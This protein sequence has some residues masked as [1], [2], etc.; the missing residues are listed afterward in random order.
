[1]QKGVLSYREFL[2]ESKIPT[3]KKYRDRETIYNYEKA[4]K[5]NYILKQIYDKGFL[6]IE[7]LNNIAEKPHA[8][9]FS[10]NKDF[11]RSEFIR[12]RRVYKLTRWGEKLVEKV[13]GL[14]EGFSI[15]DSIFNE[16]LVEP[17]YYK[18]DS[19]VSYNFWNPKLLADDDNELNRPYKKHKDLA[20]EIEDY[21]NQSKSK[22]R[23]KM[24][25]YKNQVVN[26]SGKVQIKNKTRIQKIKNSVRWI[27][28]NVM[29]YNKVPK[30]HEYETALNFLMANSQKK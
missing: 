10:K 26:K 15:N 12:G 18:G 17:S 14:N 27:I 9:W 20:K 6:T 3:V 22:F 28:K 16:K 11:V 5:R 2:N 19:P 29:P 23:Y 30:D 21:Y 4:S 24:D 13:Y 1:M 25:V 8:S 7:E